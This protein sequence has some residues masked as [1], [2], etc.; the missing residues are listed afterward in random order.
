MLA[1][2]GLAALGPFAC[3]S[4][5][6]DVIPLAASADELSATIDEYGSGS[7]SAPV[8]TPPGTAFN[9]NLTGVTPT[10]FYGDAKQSINSRVADF[11]QTGTVAGLLL[12]AT[13]TPGSTAPA[14]ATTPSSIATTQAASLVQQGFQALGA[15]QASPTISDRDALFQAAGDAST[16]AIFQTLGN[17]VLASQFADKKVLF[18]VVTVAVN[19]GW[20]TK[21]GYSADVSSQTGYEYSLARLSVV[22]NLLADAKV[23]LGIRKRVAMTYGL[24]IPFGTADPFDPKRPVPQ[25]YAVPS[26]NELLAI[27]PQVAAVAPMTQS[28]VSQ[29]L[30]SRYSQVQ[31]ALQLSAAFAKAGLGAQANVMSQYANDVQHDVD[32][33]DLNTTVNTYT[34][35]GGLFGFEVGP[36]LRATEDADRQSSV[37]ADLLERQSFP[38]LVIFGFDANDLRPRVKIDQ[39]GQMRVYE[40]RIK[41]TTFTTWHPLNGGTRRVTAQ[42]RLSRFQRF[43]DAKNRVEEA[44]QQQDA[45]I[46]SDDVDEFLDELVMMAA[47]PPAVEPADKQDCNAFQ[48][49]PASRHNTSAGF[50]DRFS[51]LAIPFGSAPNG[52]SAPFANSPIFELRSGGLENNP[53]T[54]WSNL[55]AALQAK[56]DSLRGDPAQRPLYHLLITYRRFVDERA[57]LAGLP[58]SARETAITYLGDAANAELTAITTAVAKSIPADPPADTATQDQITRQLLFRTVQ[59]G[60]DG[61][62]A[63]LKTDLVSTELELRKS[64]VASAIDPVETCKTDTLKTD[65]ETLAKDLAYLNVIMAQP[66]LKP[67]DN[68]PPKDKPGNTATKPI[69]SPDQ[70]PAEATALAAIGDDIDAAIELDQSA[71]DLLNDTNQRNQYLLDCA[72]AVQKALFPEEYLPQ[73]R[74]D[75]TVLGLSTLMAADRQAKKPGVRPSA[76]NTEGLGLSYSREL[77]FKAFGAVYDEPLPIQLVEAG[78]VKNPAITRAITDFVPSWAK[79]YPTETDTITVSVIGTDLDATDSTSLPTSLEIK[80]F[81]TPSTQ[82]DPVTITDMTV[83]P[84]LV[85]VHLTV[86]PSYRLPLALQFK[87]SGGTSVLNSVPFIIG[88]PGGLDPKQTTVVRRISGPANDPSQQQKDELEVIGAPPGT[89]NAE[90]LKAK[91]EESKPESRKRVDVNVE[92]G[93]AK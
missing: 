43:V 20:R 1:S 75:T 49:Q 19:P 62:V 58:Q 73:H 21:R 65:R 26:D 37:P 47:V 81:G 89:F 10:T 50:A 34:V 84:T 83:T 91:V 9:F 27:N 55:A 23:D 11:S 42:E 66:P 32:T 59:N 41:L 72:S 86:A 45:E 46:A 14:V 90:V 8:F 78:V 48:L 63:K 28:Q 6:K 24:Q 39:F 70:K 87:L 3:N 88:P 38:A 77:L 64:T 85:T 35:D 57:E 56:A 82:P 60:I 52:L 40:P 69:K 44:A 25:E 12:S 93:K 7:M 74:T 13:V 2:V 76:N 79:P 29:D 17:Q 16:N 4:L 67:E 30:N 61:D 18:G 80:P 5:P 68:K 22:Q 54:H 51:K 15:N 36:R 53:Q 71:V 33:L 92:L 31:L